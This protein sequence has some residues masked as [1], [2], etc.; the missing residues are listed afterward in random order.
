MLIANISNNTFRAMNKIRENVSLLY[1]LYNILLYKNI[2]KVFVIMTFIIRGYLF[3]ILI[4]VTQ[5][6][7]A[8][9]PHLICIKK[10]LIGL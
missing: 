4:I 7:F 1:I 5:Q 9:N 3:K 2:E 10:V 6:K 8:L